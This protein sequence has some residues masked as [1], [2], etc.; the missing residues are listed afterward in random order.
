MFTWRG[1]PLGSPKTAF[2]G[3]IA[4]AGLDGVTWH[5]L[6]RTWASWHTMRG[7]PPDVLQKLGLKYG[8]TLPARRLVDLVCQRIAAAK[9]ICGW[10][11]GE[12]RGYEWSVCGGVKSADK[13]FQKA[14]AERM[15]IPG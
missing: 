7:T 1:K 13:S 4:R 12:P 15:G 10:G 5:T 3:A 11:D 8:D 2:R 9:E 6:R 14:R